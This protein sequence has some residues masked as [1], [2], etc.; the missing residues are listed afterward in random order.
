MIKQFLFLLFATC[1]LTV[2]GQNA[3]FKNLDVLTGLGETRA[4]DIRIDSDGNTILFG[5]FFGTL[6]LDPGPNT[7]NVTANSTGSVYP[8][9]IIKLDTNGNYL[10]GGVLEQTYYQTAKIQLD[11][12]NTMQS[13]P[14]IGGPWR[15]PC[16]I[17]FCPP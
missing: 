3:Y 14:E 13:S 15:A 7:V 10:W 12:S 8:S 1:V 6:D 2:S 11:D 17:S 16:G 9:Y 4:K 5:T